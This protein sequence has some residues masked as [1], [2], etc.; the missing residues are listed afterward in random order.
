[1]GLILL[2]GL[3]R[4]G[5]STVAE[6]FRKQGY[7]IL[8]MSAPLKGT[9][10]D[11]YLGEMVDLLSSASSRDLVLDRTHYGE[12]VWPLI[13]GRTP[14][15][16]E[17]D[18]DILRELE[19]A[20]DVK[21]IMMHDPDAEA[22]WQRCVENKEPLT[23]VQFSKARGLYTVLAKKYDF[24][25]LTLNDF[26]GTS[27]DK[28]KQQQEQDLS[29][30]KQSDS[31]EKLI[32]KTT[33]P[34]IDKLERANAIRDVLSRPILKTKNSH[35]SSLE[36]D[37]RSFLENELNKIFGSNRDA[38][39]SSDEISVLKMFCERLKEKNKK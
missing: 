18:L 1:M 37:I 16:K 12:F 5:K 10:S 27:L 26:L 20:A 6:E 7:E 11:Q 35:F 13:Y 8:H 4:T 28:K 33:T 31:S 15:I 14:L 25:T 38:N 19:S 34:Q 9:T 2:E 36:T 29:S 22:H 24:E 30:K 32:L 3:D 17:D 21:R 23:R 39:F